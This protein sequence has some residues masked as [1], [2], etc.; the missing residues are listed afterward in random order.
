MNPHFYM[1]CIAWKHCPDPDFEKRSAD[2]LSASV[3][4]FSLPRCLHV[5]ASQPQ[6]PDELLQ[7]TPRGYSPAYSASL[8]SYLA[9]FCTDTPQGL[10]SALLLRVRH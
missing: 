5:A 1:R 4:E 10:L 9:D 2:W 3:G 8:P 7:T 6:G